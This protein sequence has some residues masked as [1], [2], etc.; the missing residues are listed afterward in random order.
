MNMEEHFKQRKKCQE[1]TEMLLETE[2]L[3]CF[4][5]KLMQTLKSESLKETIT[6]I[7]NRK[8]QQDNA[9]E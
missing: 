9:R 8:R 7:R 2:L 1:L 4:G 6:K 3:R 5:E